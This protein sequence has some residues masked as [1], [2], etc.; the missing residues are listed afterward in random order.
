MELTEVAEGV[1]QVS[2]TGHLDA[3]GVA[4]IETGF[5][6]MLSNSQKSAIVDMTGVEF[7]GSL[8][9]RMLLATARVMERRGR[10]MV[11]AGARPEVRQVFD[12]VGLGA[13]VPLANTLADAKAMLA[14]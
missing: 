12:T 10:K 14:A 8:G 7:C 6:A 11:I 3:A 2:L 1:Q 9:V 4:R 5:T 13:L